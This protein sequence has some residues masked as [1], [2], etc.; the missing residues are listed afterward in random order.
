MKRLILLPGSLVCALLLMGCD[1]TG[2]GS[3]PEPVAAQPAPATSPSNAQAKAKG[4]RN[5]PKVFNPGNPAAR[6]DR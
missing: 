4:A 6:P 2:S 5:F 1:S 3:S